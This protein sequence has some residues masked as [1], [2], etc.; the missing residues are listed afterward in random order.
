MV[1]H[2]YFLSVVEGIKIISREY[3]A[4][5]FSVRIRQFTIQIYCTIYFTKLSGLL[6]L[7]APW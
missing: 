4:V 2:L 6:I 7:A 3:S 1:C 5:F